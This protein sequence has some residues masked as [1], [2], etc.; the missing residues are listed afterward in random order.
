V[1][2][3]DRFAGSSGE[4]YKQGLQT[5]K[6]FCRRPQEF[7]SAYNGLK[8]YTEAAAA[9]KRATVIEPITPRRISSWA[10]HCTTEAASRKPS[11]R[12]RKCETE[13]RPRPGSLQ[14]GLAYISIN[15]K[16]LALEEYNA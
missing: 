11:G 6:K 16:T 10:K 4:S 13:A 3:G 9:L 5:G 15:D 12:T 1:S 2:E 8:R 7:G 14:L